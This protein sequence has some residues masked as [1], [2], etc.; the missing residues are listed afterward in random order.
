MNK[1]VLIQFS[2]FL[3]VLVTCFVFY[4]LFFKSPEIKLN[5]IKKDKQENKILADQGTNQME[6]IIYNS[7]YSDDNQYTIKAEFGQFNKDDPDLML[8]TNVKGT[9][10]LNNSDIIKISSDKAKY[11][12]ENYNTNFYQNVLIIFDNH[13]INSD[14]FDLFFDKKVS[15]I[16]NNVIYKNLNTTL[17][18]DKVDIDLIT[19]D[20]KIYMMDKSKKV[21]IKS[22]N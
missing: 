22:I 19:K 14:N 7:N 8:L 13:R 17:R 6:D 11:N 12:S 10:L 15:T 3:I 4:R 21:K 20:S 2:L 5:D 16:Y 9:I 18:A 1:K